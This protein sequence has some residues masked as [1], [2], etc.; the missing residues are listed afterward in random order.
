[1][2]PHALI[3][4]FSDH[5]P[6]ASL[7][8]FQTR[9]KYSHAAVWSPRRQLLWES[10]PGTGVRRITWTRNQA[11]RSK[12]SFFTVPSMTEAG[13]AEAMEWA[14]RQVGKGYDY[15]GVLRFL[16]RETRDNRNRFF[17]S[18]FD[19]EFALRGG[20]LLLHNIQPYE[21]SPALLSFSPLMEPFDIDT[22]IP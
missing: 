10:R 12:A 13:M 3:V 5:G 2:M 4:L 21:V 7:I 22:L 15:L 20:V 1:M 8:R 14:D 9:S 16:S 19:F 18:E 6:V 17:C 11:R